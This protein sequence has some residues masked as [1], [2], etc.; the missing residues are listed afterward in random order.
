[1]L[2]HIRAALLAVVAAVAMV[3]V[4]PSAYAAVEINKASLAELEAV[5]GVGTATAGKIVDERKK[6]VFKDWNDLMQRVGG[7]KQARAG[8]LSEAG[9][10]VNGKAFEAAA[11]PADKAAKPADGKVVAKKQP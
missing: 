1:M 6:S 10:T 4:S 8:K 9:L 7:I 3:T 11:A 2:K 5:K